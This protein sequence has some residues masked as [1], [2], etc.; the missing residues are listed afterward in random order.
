MS[1]N[2]RII[3]SFHD[4]VGSL[5]M[6]IALDVPAQG[7]TAVFGPSGSGKTTL[8]R[9]LAGLHQAKDGFC[10]VAG[11]VWQQDRFFLPTHKRL[12]GYVFQDAALFPHLCVR[13]NLLFGASKSMRE[14][15][16]LWNGIIAALELQPLISRS[17]HN[18]SG[19][20]KQR[21]AIGRALLSEPQLLL[22]DEPL[23]ALDEASK[24]EILP[25]LER[26]CQG[27]SVPL[28]YVSH[29][30]AEIERIADTL[31]LMEQGHILA[32]GPLHQLQTNP[33]LPLFDSSNAAITL[34]A[35]LQNY[36]ATYGLAQFDVNG[37][38]FFVPTASRPTAARHRL[39]ILA[40]DV[41][42]SL[43]RPEQSSILNAVPVVIQHAKRS[44]DQ[45]MTLSLRLNPSNAST[46]SHATVLLARITR[47]SWDSLELKPGMEIF[48]SVKSVALERG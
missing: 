24:R 11:Q 18:L 14:G 38:Q 20:E 15:G 3:A 22:M 23:S 2:A 43:I 32:Q 35:T 36:D 12:I 41:S 1:S 27:L 34:E 8:L 28:I 16:D 47:R 42:L 39:K 13:K 6:D 48:A 25:L 30:M 5:A 9:T 17:V 44:D 21:V 31:V 19:G 26:L 7:V 37:A 46:I 10:S 33:D 4:Q 40:R 29:N 45:H